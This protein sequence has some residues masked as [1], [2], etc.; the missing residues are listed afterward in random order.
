MALFS[1]WPLNGN[2]DDTIGPNDLVPSGATYDTIIKH[3]GSASG[4]LDAFNDKFTTGDA[5]TYKFLHGA[6]DNFSFQFSIGVW[7]ALD[8]PEHDFV[9]TL[10]ST[11]SIDSSIAGLSL[12]HDDRS[13]SGHSRR[14]ALFI[15]NGSSG[16]PVISHIS[17]DNV[18]PNDSDFH[19]VVVTYDQALVS[20]NSKM[21]IDNVLVSTGDKTGNS[22]TGANSAFPFTVGALGASLGHLGGNVDAPTIWDHALSVGEINSDWNG[23]VGIEYGV[24]APTFQAAW[25]KNANQIIGAAQ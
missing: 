18:Y 1:S 17:P 4:K 23:G 6:I 11:A 13:S 25:A 12:W 7:M 9:H 20:A 21:Y 14:L 24:V 8:V 10:C 2:G 5:S 3:L 19:R 16:N 22:P 15:T